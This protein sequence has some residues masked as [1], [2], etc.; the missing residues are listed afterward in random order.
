[1]EGGEAFGG[2]KVGGSFDPLTFLKKPCV[3]FRIA[4]LLFSVIAF[5]CISSQ[6][7]Q[8]HPE[9]EKEVCIMNGSGTACQ[10]GNGVAIVAF[11]ASIGFLVGEY[12]FEQMSSVKSRKHFVVAD[13]AFSGFW[14]FAYLI[15]FSTMAYQW[16]Q[17]EEPASGYG[18]G[19]IGGAI[20]FSFLSIFA[21]GGCAL[22]SLQRYNVGFEAAFGDLEATAGGEYQ[23]YDQ[24]G[25]V[26]PPFQQQGGE[27]EF[28][29]VQY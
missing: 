23:S 22:F 24:N 14:A 3:V 4:A 1:M 12:F 7:W 13:L 29:Q 17:S 25:Y 20:L 11:L 8:F 2:G 26:E 6:G 28:Q 16:S 9:K 18:Q 15:S 27:A 5:G 21:W 10:L 19:N